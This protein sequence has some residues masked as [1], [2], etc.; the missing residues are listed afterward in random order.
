LYNLKYIFEMH[1]LQP[2]FFLQKF[3]IYL[4]IIQ[5]RNLFYAAQFKNELKI[6]Q[7]KNVL[8]DY[9]N[10]FLKYIFR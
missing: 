3:I 5:F 8:Q 6:I 2:T 1:N 7:F 9:I 4:Q 10:I